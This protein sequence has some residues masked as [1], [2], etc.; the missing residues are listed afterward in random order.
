MVY[1][2]LNWGFFMSYSKF[3]GV[4]SITANMAGKKHPTMITIPIVTI[5]KCIITIKSL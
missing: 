2:P 4:V 3:L 1:K 5:P